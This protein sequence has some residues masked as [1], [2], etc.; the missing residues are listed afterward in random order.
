[1]LPDGRLHVYF[2]DVGQGD[3]I[4]LRTPGGRL[5]LVDGGPDPL[6]L[7]SRLGEVLPFWQRRIDLVVSTH[8]DQDHAGGLEGIVGRYQ[9][10]HIIESPVKGQGGSNPHWREQ[11]SSAGARILTAAQGMRVNL[12]KGLHLDVLNPPAHALGE[13]GNQN[14]V[15]LRVTVGRCRL[16][17]AGDISAQVEQTLLE[18][19]QPVQ[20]TLLKV[21]HHGAATSS[22]APFLSAVG[23]QVAVIGVGKG[24]RFGHP[25][26]EVLQRLSAIGCQVLRTDQ[27]GTIELVTDGRAYWVKPHA[28]GR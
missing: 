15:V 11:L 5:I 19:G 4:L 24:N 27:Q 21:A 28:T 25:S 17:L 18:G 22:S 1:M 14:S 9:V 23:P 6:V 26:E 13:D 3:A 2:L 8:A 16:L 20:A 7:S 12:G 10:T